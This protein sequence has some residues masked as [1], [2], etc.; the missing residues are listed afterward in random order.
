MTYATAQSM[1]TEFGEREI[2]LL[3]DRGGAGQIDESVLQ[4]A[5]DHADRLI[6]AHLRGLV[7]TPLTTPVP[8]EILSIAQDLARYRLY[9]R[10]E[11]PEVVR[12]RFDQAMKMLRDYR[13]GRLQLPVGLIEDPE[14][15]GQVEAL[16]N[17]DDRLF[18]LG[19]WSGYDL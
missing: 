6:D 18:R 10:G 1:V 5:L 7:A 11:T 14:S 16:R 12:S 2:R 17:D 13:D 9:D 3:T 15:E 8:G 19:T 4:G